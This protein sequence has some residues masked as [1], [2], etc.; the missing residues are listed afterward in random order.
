MIRGPTEY[1]PPVEVEVVTKRCV[2]HMCT[3][4]G[5]THYS[6]AIPLDDNE[7]IY[8]RDCKSGKVRAVCGKTYMLNHN[9]ELWEKDL[10][11]TIEELL[12]VRRTRTHPSLTGRRTRAIRWASAATATRSPPARSR[13]ATRRAS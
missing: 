2:P 12:A 13:P 4:A 10:P 7:G 6:K 8:V 5:V 1:V 9:E 11:P 3:D